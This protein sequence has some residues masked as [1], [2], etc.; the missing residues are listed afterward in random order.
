MTTDDGQW[1]LPTD[2][3]RKVAG[4]LTAEDHEFLTLDTQQRLLDWGDTSGTVVWGETT[5][6]TKV[7]LLGC[8]VRSMDHS[9]Q[10]AHVHVALMGAHIASTDDA[11][12]VRAVAGITN[13]TDW[14]TRNPHSPTALP[15]PIPHPQRTGES[16]DLTSTAGEVRLRVQ[17]D[18]P[19]PW[20]GFDDT[21]RSIQ[22]L[23]TLAGNA[24]CRIETVTLSTVDATTV[25][26]WTKTT[27]VIDDR[28]HPVF[29]LSSIDAHVFIPAWLKLRTRI[30]MSG[31]VLFSLDYGG[32]GYFQNKL[33][34]AASAA[35]GIH[36]ALWPKRR[37]ID[38]AMYTQI[39]AHIE[40][41]EDPKAKDWVL[42]Q[43]QGNRP[44][45]ADRMRQLAAHPDAL[46]VDGLLH[47][48]EQWI[49][50][51]RDAR[52]AIGHSSWRGMNKIPRDVRPSL[53][54]VT[55]TLLHLVLLE[56]LKMTPQQQRSAVDVSYYGWRQ[57]YDDYMNSQTA[58]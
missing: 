21:V 32:P 28:W 50:W 36:Q 29:A 30:G 2:P 25:E 49:R 27:P 24:D 17:S 8:W 54:Y 7:T 43:I 37:G 20:F 1:W 56:E 51:M 57:P 58:P 45:L 33:F 31:A 38:P 46:A 5:T 9:G 42:K 10:H 48:R 14:A 13:L 35:E 39:A 12:F 34:N 6:G 4:T 11:L 44:S 16:I 23:L 3:D 26:I 55:K 15:S 41:L 40:K 22:D 19:R 18:E 52:N 47:D 53:T